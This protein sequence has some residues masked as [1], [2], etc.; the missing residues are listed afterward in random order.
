MNHNLGLLFGIGFAYL[1]LLFLIAFA[2]DRGR[3]PEKLIRHPLVYVF[4]LGV[5]AT[6]WTYYGSV[7]FAQTQGYL[8]LS[9]YLGVTLAFALSPLL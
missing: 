5:Y 6:S 7:G 9:I 8:F 2:A 3:L 1:V 4:S